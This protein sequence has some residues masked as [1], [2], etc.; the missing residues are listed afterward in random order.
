MGF[1]SRAGRNVFAA[2]RQPKSVN[3][4]GLTNLVSSPWPA[5]PDARPPLASMKTD[6]AIEAFAFLEI[7]HDK[8]PLAAHPSRVGVHLFQRC[9]DMRRE[10]DLC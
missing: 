9:A 10:V 6:D 8:R 7:G 5:P 4:S 1:V 2:V 3:E